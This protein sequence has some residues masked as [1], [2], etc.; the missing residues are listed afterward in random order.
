[1]VLQVWR[2]GVAGIHRSALCQ[3]TGL[4]PAELGSLLIQMSHQLRRFQQGQRAMLFRPVTSNSRRQSYFVNPEFAA[5]AESQMFAEPM[6]H[7][8]A[9]GAGRP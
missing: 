5:V 7:Q 3:H 1:M 6:S 9:D 4:T 2:A 8:M